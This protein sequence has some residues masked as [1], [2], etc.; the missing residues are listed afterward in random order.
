[1]YI[2]LLLESWSHN[3]SIVLQCTSA[4]QGDKNRRTTNKA[5]LTQLDPDY[6]P[7]IPLVCWWIVCVGW[8]LQTCDWLAWPKPPRSTQF[9]HLSVVCFYI[10]W[11]G[12]NLRENSHLSTFPSTSPNYHLSLKFI[13]LNSLPFSI[14]S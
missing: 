11:S 12:L 2:I 4:I 7:N 13:D 14:S 1:M 6:K 5:N 10:Q 3:R 8:V 9:S